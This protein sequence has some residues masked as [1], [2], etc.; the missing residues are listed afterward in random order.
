MSTATEPK[1]ICKGCWDKN[2]EALHP[3]SHFD[4]RGSSPYCKRCKEDR[5]NAVL[6]LVAQGLTNQ[7]IADLL[8]VECDTINSYL[9]TIRLKTGIRNRVLLSFYALGKGIVTQD[10]IRAAINQER[11]REKKA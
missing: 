5:V 6:S 1:K 4:N 11:E 3:F 2:R 8:K 7:E 9:R 10:E